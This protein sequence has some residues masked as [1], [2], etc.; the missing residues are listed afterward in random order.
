MPRIVSLI[1]SATEIVCRLGFAD[2]L[3]GRS[4]ECDFPDSINSLPQFT[5]P[6]FDVLGS[7]REI[8]QRVKSVLED[9]TSVYRVDAAMLKELKPDVIV[10]QTQCDVC[11]VSEKD[12]QEA[13]SSWVGRDAHIV[14]LKPDG[15]A[16]VWRD[17][18]SVAAALQVPD[19]GEQLV[20]DLQGRMQR[21]AAT[22]RS[23]EP[24][25]RVALLEW[26]DPLMAA[27]IWMPDL[28]VMAGGVNLFGEAGKHSPWLNWEDLRDAD[29]DYIIS[30]P[31]GFDMAKNQSEL[32]TLANKPE[33]STLTAAREG[34]VFVTDGNQFFNRPGPRLAESLEILAEIL[35]PDHFQFGHQGTGWQRF[36][37]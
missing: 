32:E 24:K 21:I 16:D 13:V 35:H 28:L 14:S 19:Q 27:G 15:L 7:S 33:W 10:T 30:L 31:C 3:I 36:L 11:A 23:L 34:R 17:I 1:A 6:K 5:L 9:A 8:D 37:G 22:S 20:N 18:K 2:D 4:H 12:V 25:P 29:P 26:L